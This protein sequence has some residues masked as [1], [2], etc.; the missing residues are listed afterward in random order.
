MKNMTRNMNTAG[1]QSGF[2]IIELIVVILLL[3]ILT[4]TAL[5]RFIDVTDEA[6]AAAF[7]GVLGGF[8]TG[9]ALG[10]A[11]WVAGGQ[12]TTALPDFSNAFATS[13]GVIAG[14]ANASVDEGD[15]KAIF[16][17]VLQSGR[18]TI[19]TDTTT[20]GTGAGVT[21]T[22]TAAEV[23]A[24][25]AAGAND[26]FAFYDGGGGGGVTECEYYY[27]GAGIAENALVPNFIL[28]YSTG[29]ITIGT[30]LTV[31]P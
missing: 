17:I 13:N 23:L 5:P 26:W 25:T 8:T 31:Q 30:N 15:C 19:A 24:A 11:Q 21:A 28:D 7:D 29:E 20:P 22:L 9:M 27:G 14:T 10:R 4:A 3:G 6:H 16:D 18:P 1:R 12:P 2:T